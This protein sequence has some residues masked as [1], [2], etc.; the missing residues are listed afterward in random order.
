MLMKVTEEKW[1]MHSHMLNVSI[2]KLKMCETIPIDEFFMPPQSENWWY[3]LVITSEFRSLSAFFVI[4]QKM[5]IY[6]FRLQLIICQ[7]RKFDVVR[8]HLFV[9][10]KN[11]QN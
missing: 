9:E 2:V 7:D 11:L 10:I 6:I 4:S 8:F 1:Y 5:L 3:G